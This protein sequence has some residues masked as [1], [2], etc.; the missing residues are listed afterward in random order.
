[1]MYAPLYR[2]A[3]EDPVVFALLA[4]TS[5]SIRL[6][7]FDQAPKDAPMPYATWQNIGGVPNNNVSDRPDAD[8]FSVQV[9]V[10]AM[11]SAELW[12]VVEAL[13]DVMEVDGCTIVRWGA[14]VTDEITKALGY[15]FDVDCITYR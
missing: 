10:W 11:T 5:E 2:I 15:D 1:M 12:A 9:N 13:R 7:P 14:T 3:L 4:D 8:F 6:W